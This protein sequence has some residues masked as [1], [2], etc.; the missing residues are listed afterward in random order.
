MER[1]GFGSGKEFVVGGR[2]VAAFWEGASA[3]FGAVNS[4]TAAI[5]L[6]SPVNHRL[7][8]L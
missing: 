4:A 2:E 6:D 7:H 8:I 1:S 3:K 5:L